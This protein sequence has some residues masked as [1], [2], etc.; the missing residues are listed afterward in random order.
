MKGRYFF[1]AALTAAFA[2]LSYADPPKEFSI[3]PGF[4]I[5]KDSP[6]FSIT[7]GE[8]LK[9]KCGC[10]DCKCP[11]G[12][13]PDCDATAKKDPM[14]FTCRI[15]VDLG[16][17]TAHGTGT[18]IVS[19]NGKTLIL[20]N[21]HVVSVTDKPISVQFGDK[22]Y[23]AR[24]VAGSQVRDVAPGQ[25]KV[26]GPDLCVL[27]IDGTRDVVEF[28]DELPAIGEAVYQYGFGGS[29]DGKP[30]YRTGTVVPNPSATPYLTSN[31]RG[32]SGDSGC[33]VFDSRG[34]MLGV[35][36][37]GNGV[38]YA[39]TV[40]TVNGF[41]LAKANTIFRLF[42]K[43]R[44]RVAARRLARNPVEVVPAPD[45]D[46]SKKA[47]QAPAPQP[48]FDAAPPKTA[49]LGS[50]VPPKPTAAGDWQWDDTKKTWWKWN[51]P[52]VAGSNCPDGNCP[53]P[54]VFYMP[55]RVR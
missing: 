23:S 15:S 42:P 14:W 47:P 1:A 19:E 38:S 48:K 37:G 39:E 16:N 11:A 44:E 3:S 32:V 5:T 12:V 20:T 6:G 27:E 17:A 18:P 43:A 26:D 49:P 41:L 53:L 29:L 52:G 34:R 33:A 50:G 55:R 24:Y 25:I 46:F 8:V 22:T 7:K 9:S 36:W 21:A 10:T 4:N 35:G 51:T 28:A 2:S 31:L 40:S 13:C 54:G 30:V 45:T